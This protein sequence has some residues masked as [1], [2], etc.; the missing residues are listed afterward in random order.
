MEGIQP[1]VLW[2]KGIQGLTAM[3]KEARL[4]QTLVSENVLSTFQSTSEQK[5]IDGQH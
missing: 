3:W 1:F 5:I 2:V 4:G